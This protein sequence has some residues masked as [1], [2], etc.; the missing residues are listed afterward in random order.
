MFTP[1]VLSLDLAVLQ[2]RFT[3][4]HRGWRK[5]LGGFRSDKQEL[6]AGV[7]DPAGVK[8]QS[9]PCLRH[10]HGRRQNE[11]WPRRWLS[12]GQRWAPTSAV[13]RRT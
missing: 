3:Q 5:I 1:T 7:K 10:E 9:M 12:R 4:T 2:Q 13:S 11:T 8:A 6:A